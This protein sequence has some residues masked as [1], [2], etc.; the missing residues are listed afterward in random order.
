MAKSTKEHFN[1]LL[2]NSIKSVLIALPVLIS[3][4]K[5]KHNISNNFDIQNIEKEIV[6]QEG[7][8]I[9]LEKNF[10]LGILSYKEYILEKTQ[11]RNS[12][13]QLI[14]DIDENK[15]L[16]LFFESKE[17]EELS[18]KIDKVEKE[19]KWEDTKQ[20]FKSLLPYLISSGILIF[21]LGYFICF[22]NIPP[23]Y[24]E[25]NPSPNDT[26]Y[27]IK[28]NAKVHI[29]VQSDAIPFNYQDNDGKRKGIDVE[30]AKLIFSEPE[31]GLTNTD[32]LNLEHQVDEYDEI[33]SLLDKKD[34]D[35]IMGGLTFKDGDKE[36]IIF[37]EPYID[38]YGYCLV[39]K[40]ND[41]IKEI[42]DL[43]NK[44]IGYVN[45][46]TD[47]KAYLDSMGIKGIPL[48]DL[49]GWL[50]D[51]IK[52][53]KVDAIVYDFLYASSEIKGTS[54]EI[55]IPNLPNH[56]VNY[57]I[58]IRAGNYKLRDELNKVIRRI[59]DNEK[60]I[61]L[62]NKYSPTDQ[63]NLDISETE[64][65]REKWLVKKGQ[66]LTYVLNKHCGHSNCIDFMV[67]LNKL[68]SKDEIIAGKTLYL[69]KDCEKCN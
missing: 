19:E 63:I 68:T 36:N 34:I 24:N 14:E 16:E 5:K 46:D 42:E 17:A 54:L 64:R 22:I 20:E 25:N 53:G 26:Y 41:D 1:A 30:I 65:N 39:S 11:I 32:A 57:S 62:L 8:L 12:V 59:K 6:L 9:A 4:H 45:G 66:T 10:R 56:K 55:D 28:S 40:K 38:G 51:N 27:H 37:T 31:F 47:V 23:C 50:A 61:N 60:Y 52:G 44:K 18:S 33:P 7:R 2:K 69:P 48:E 58:G 21:F 35:I 3:S 43:R 49:T 15:D 67:T 29:G 13:A